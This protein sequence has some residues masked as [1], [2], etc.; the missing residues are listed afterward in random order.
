MANYLPTAPWQ[1]WV[2]GCRNGDRHCQRHLFEHFLPMVMGVAL[3]YTASYEDAC[4]VA[5]E[6]FI[7]VFEKVG[8]LRDVESFP[9]WL[10]RT[11]VHTAIDFLRGRRRFEVL[12]EGQEGPVHETVFD[13]HAHIIAKCLATLPDGYRTILNLYDIEGYS[14]HEIAQM[15]NI[16]E[17]TSRSQLAKARKM[18]QRLLK[19]HGIG[20]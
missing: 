1:K 16:S 7:K 5:Q 18:M 12:S 15:L 11:A 10:R 14:H 13:S 20:G 6:T 17:G 3:R 4:D 2:D 9:A 19:Q 8:N